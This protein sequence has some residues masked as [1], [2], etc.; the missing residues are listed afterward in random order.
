[1]QVRAKSAH[2]FTPERV[3][4]YRKAQESLPSVR[5]RE[6][7]PILDFIK[8][9]F[10][11]GKRGLELGS[12]SGFLTTKLAQLG[13]HMETIDRV[14]PKPPGS[15]NHRLFNLSEG[16]P[17]DLESDFDY[18]VS[19]ACLHHVVSIPQQ[20][21]DALATAI[22]ALAAPGAYLYFEDVP[23]RETVK[24]YPTTQQFGAAQ[25]ARFFE[26]VVDRYSAPSHDGI[27][28]DMDFIAAQLTSLGWRQ[29][30]CFLN[31]CSWQFNDEPRLLSYVRELFNLQISESQ[32][33]D[34]LAD[35]DH[36]P[37]GVQLPW[38][39]HCLV[40]RKGT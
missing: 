40:M 3:A 1:M 16:L 6:I 7:Q 23:N 19:L 37:N 28:L 5:A 30:A 24:R 9:T 18:F 29:E 21:P 4:L 20:L 10:P 38:G 2:P 11:K 26:E 35:L 12:G 14:F 25:T 8:S 31:E 17:H 39:L 22:D 15:R 34:M 36:G 33:L 13:I 32:L 27:Y